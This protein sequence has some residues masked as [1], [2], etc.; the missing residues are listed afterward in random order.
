MPRPSLLDSA[1]TPF[2]IVFLMWLLFFLEIF[3][4]F[5]LSAFGI[6]PL[7]FHGL[8][9]VLMA[10]LLHGSFNHL[11]SNS[12]PLLFLG[13]VL[14]FFYPA[15]G[16]NVFVRCYFITNILVWI[17]ARHSNHIGASGLVYGLAFFLIFFGIFRRDFLS[18]LISIIIL[19]MYG[20]VFYG[21]LPSD[22]RIS[23]ESHLAG[24]VV[25]VWTA[26]TYG[27]KKQ[28]N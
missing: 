1:S 14:F 2:R 3:S 12:V 15:I 25:G 17:F 22:P 10:P 8:I 21:V 9:G 23:W 4:G 20:G 7:T 16:N 28:V 24:A 6:E 5:P 13:T 26:I 18:M 11:V 19:L 27:D